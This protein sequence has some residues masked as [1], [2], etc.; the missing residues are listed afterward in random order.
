MIDR[1]LDQGYAST[2][3]CSALIHMMQGRAAERAIRKAGTGTSR[4]GGRRR[5]FG[6]EPRRGEPDGVGGCA[7]GKSRPDGREC[8]D[9]GIGRGPQCRAGRAAQIV[10]ASRRTKS[11]RPAVPA[12]KPGFTTLFFNVG[13]KDLVTPA[14]L[15]GKIAGVTRL[16]AS[17]VGAIDIHQRHSLVDVVAKEVAHVIAKIDRRAREGSGDAAG[18]GGGALL[19]QPDRCPGL[20]LECGSCSRFFR[21]SKRQQVTHLKGRQGCYFPPPYM[22]AARVTGT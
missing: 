18:G 14:D 4:D 3:I 15:V 21:L 6:E 13:R 12:A 17:V 19:V 22:P 9:R 5:A 16:P 1:L 7:P 8:R 10:R 11:K 2:D 20:P